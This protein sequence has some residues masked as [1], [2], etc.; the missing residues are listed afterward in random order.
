MPVRNAP[1]VFHSEFHPARGSPLRYN[2]PTIDDGPWTKN[3]PS[4]IDHRQSSQFDREGFVLFEF[5]EIKQVINHSAQTTNGDCPSTIVRG[6]FFPM[7]DR[8][9]SMV[10]FPFVEDEHDGE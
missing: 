4:T 6:R 1:P 9:W 2:F 10:G 8:R 5:S 3:R 7:V